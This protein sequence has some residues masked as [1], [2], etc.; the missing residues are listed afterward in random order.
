MRE[1]PFD[2]RFELGE[3]RVHLVHGSPR[4]V[5]EYLFED[6]PAQPLRAPRRRRDR[7]TCSSSATPTSRGSTSTA[8]CCSS[9]A[10]RSASPR[11]ATRAAPSRSSARR[12]SRRHDRARRVRRRARWQTRSRPPACP[13][14]FADKLVAARMT[15]PL[16]R[17]LLAEY[18]GSAFLAAVVIGSGIA[19]SRLSPD[20]TGLALLEN[21]AA[22]AAGL[23]AI[24]LMFGPVSGGHFNPVVSLVDAA[25]RRTHLARRARL[26]PRPGRR[27][28]HRRDH[29]Q[30]HVRADARS[31]SPPTTAPAPRTC[32]PRSSRR[33]GCCS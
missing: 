32:S 21:A 4:K 31:A 18:L 12:R 19:A 30:R 5:N 20:D 8:A 16:A 7:A 28:H 22:T 1:L 9:T 3:Q 10:A 17:R 2:L 23:F 11:T 26:H 13:R 15:A 6:K 29:R 14:E 24:I 27:L 25:L 33:W